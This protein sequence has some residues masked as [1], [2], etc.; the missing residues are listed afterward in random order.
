MCKT[1]KY[2]SF[3]NIFRARSEIRIIHTFV[4]RKSHTI[5]K[6]GIRT[7][8]YCVKNNIQNV[9]LGGIGIWVKPGFAAVV[10]A[11]I[12]PKHPVFGF[13]AN[14]HIVRVIWRCAV[15]KSKNARNNVKPHIFCG[16]YAF[17]NI[18]GFFVNGAGIDNAY[19]IGSICYGALPG[20]HIQNNRGNF[21]IQRF[22]EC[23]KIYGTVKKFFR[24]GYRN[25]FFFKKLFRK[26]FVSRFLR[27]C[28]NRILFYY[29]FVFFVH[30]LHKGF[31]GK[32]AHGKKHRRCKNDCHGFYDFALY[33]VIN[34]RTIVFYFISSVHNKTPLCGKLM[35]DKAIECKR[36]KSKI[37]K[38]NGY[39]LKNFWNMAVFQSGKAVSHYCHSKTKAKACAYSVTDGA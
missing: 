37:D 38:R 34:A 5:Q 36:E 12:K 26:R 33:W 18:H 4:F 3:G 24:N 39:A 35:A 17:I 8:V 9:L 13:I 29:F 28:R 6:N 22:K 32:P 25:C 10:N 11:V 16:F 1:G 15:F 14:G 19:L 31:I 7:A 20:L 21:F 2:I 23:I 27:F 30:G